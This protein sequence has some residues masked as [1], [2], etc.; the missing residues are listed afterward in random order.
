MEIERLAGGG[1]EVEAEVGMARADTPRSAADAVTVRVGIS[2]VCF[3]MRGGVPHL[4]WIEL[5]P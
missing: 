5:V 2:I 4:N 1:P 3:L